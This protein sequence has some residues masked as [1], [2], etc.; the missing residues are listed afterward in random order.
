MTI[1]KLQPGR[2]HGRPTKSVH[3]ADLILSESLHEAGST[4][5]RHA[6][7]NSYFCFVL[8]GG[9]TERYQNREVE[10]RVA[11]LTFRKSG[12]THE[13]A[14]HDADTRVFVLEL[15]PKW[16]D[17]LRA[18][19]LTLDTTSDFYHGSAP[20]L[21]AKLSREF[22]QTDGAAKLAIEGLALE[23]F[24]EASRGP[25]AMTGRVPPWLKRASDMLAENFT[26]NL[27]LRQIA[28]EVGVH[29]VHL[30]S[31]F[32]HKFGTTVGEYVRRRRIEHAC[33]E[34]RKKAL[35]LSQIAV[36]AGFSDQSH[37]SKVFKTYTGMTPSAFRRQLS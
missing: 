1:E 13:A 9:Y 19:S 8:Q 14:V 29:P 26:E 17:R 2:L 28:S 15:S 12:Q 30:A 36:Q 11:S 34:L 21:C 23:L 24:A 20:R 33:L 18:D 35:P 5:P 6:H 32:R 25:L 4:V 22:R 16:I 3:V 10:C 31:A 37:F 7:E 27:S